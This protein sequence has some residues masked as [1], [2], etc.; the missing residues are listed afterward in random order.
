[1][2]N[3]FPGIIGRGIIEKFLRSTEVNRVFMLLR[4]KKGSSVE[5]RLKSFKD[6]P[7]FKRLKLEKPDALDKLVAI[8]GDLS[9]PLLGISTR[10]LTALG[11][12]S[13]FIH[14]AATVRFDEP[15]RVA[16]NLNVSATY[17]AM[18]LAKK[19]KQMELFVHISTY[20]SNPSLKFVENKMYPPPIDWRQAIKLSESPLQDETL[21]ILSRKY[22]GGF[23][24][25]Y[26]FTKNLS[27]NVV[28]EHSHLFPVLIVRPSISEFHIQEPFLNIKIPSQSYSH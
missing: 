22:I 27:E 23:P 16:I 20:Y 18:K 15:I 3:D 21:D 14:S 25:T 24:N 12:V 5:N 6:G 1:M 7:V 13:L 10:S 8:P 9:L 19:M 28:N 26:T 11:T 4:Y 17:E 2:K